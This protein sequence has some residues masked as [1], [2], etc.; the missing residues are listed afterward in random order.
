MGRQWLKQHGGKI[1]Q[2][3]P[4]TIPPTTPSPSLPPSP[5]FR[6][7]RTASDAPQ[8]AVAE[9]TSASASAAIGL[10][11]AGSVPNLRALLL[12]GDFFLGGVVAG[13]LVKLLLKLAAL[14]EVPG[15]SVVGRSSG[16]VGYAWLGLAW[17]RLHLWGSLGREEAAGGGA[18]SSS[19]LQGS[20]FLGM[21]GL[22]AGC[23]V[24]KQQGSGTVA[25]A[26]A[27]PAAAA[28]AA[29]CR[30]TPVNAERACPSPPNSC[31]VRLPSTA[32][33]SLPP[34]SPALNTAVN[35]LRDPSPFPP[36]PHTHSLLRMPCPPL[37]PERTNRSWRCYVP[38]DAKMAFAIPSL[39]MMQVVVPKPV[40]APCSPN[41]PTQS[42]A[43][44][45]AP[46]RSL[47]RERAQGRRH[48]DHRRHPAPGRGDG[49]DDD[50]AGRRQP[51]PHAAV[52]AR[53]V[54]PRHLLEPR[55]WPVRCVALKGGGRC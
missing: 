24:G 42:H 2:A 50:P 28:G 31:P 7:P 45:P 10:G 41:P 11:G 38:F 55:E 3:P 14:G 12:A 51:R 25:A 22:G 13:T 1:G 19:H 43:P 26:A 16:L 30:N 47:G 39:Q 36:P 46:T 23:R 37:T 15:E 9:V 17:P 21:R 49:R 44:P 40:G 54:R 4:T 53:A 33:P 32:P 35:A 8:S 5:L 18:R 6:Q 34:Q 52:H 27:L 20:G 48:A 29:A